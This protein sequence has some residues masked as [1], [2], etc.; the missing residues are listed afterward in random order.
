MQ[1]LPIKYGKIEASFV[2]EL[3]SDATNMA[4]TKG[5][6]SMA[7]ELGPEASEEYA[8]SAN[9]IEFLNTQG[10]QYAQELFRSKPLAEAAIGKIPA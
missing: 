1:S 8:E 10:Y 3:P 6:S 7:D 9:E 5:T 4:I 2:K